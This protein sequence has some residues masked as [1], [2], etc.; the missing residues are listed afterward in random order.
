M[1]TGRG[2]QVIHRSVYLVNREK[3]RTPK[4]SHGTYLGLDS[5]VLEKLQKASASSKAKATKLSEKHHSSVNKKLD[6]GSP[7]TRGLFSTLP[8]LTV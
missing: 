2:L 1:V 6:W 4:Y 3:Q 5:S 7:G 8:S